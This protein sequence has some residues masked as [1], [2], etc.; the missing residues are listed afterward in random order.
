MT[1]NTTTETGF[2][3]VFLRIMVY[4]LIVILVTIPLCMIGEWFG[5]FDALG[6]QF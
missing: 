6:I 4:A 3:D 2:L 1:Q 5:I